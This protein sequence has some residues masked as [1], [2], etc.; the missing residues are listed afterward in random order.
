M[1]V[2]TDGVLLGAWVDVEN[3]RSILDVGTG[4]G[5]VA[6]MI[7]QRC[8]DACIDAID[9]DQA[10]CKQAGENFMSS[11]WHSRLRSIH[12][13]F[14]IFAKSS[15]KYELI[16]SN[17]PYFSNSLQPFKNT[18]KIARHTI[19]LTLSQFFEACLPLMDYN[20]EVCLIIPFSSATE[21][22][23]LAA[24]H[25][26]FPARSCEVSS[27]QGHPPVRSMITFSKKPIKE[28][29]EKLHLQNPDGSFTDAYKLLTKEFYVN[30]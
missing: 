11:L 30:F 19:E 3:K 13:D 28:T 16:V 14:R 8:G 15:K 17:P 21:C 5:L 9:I 20:G 4:C 22:R 1:K 24:I 29:T 7:A 27:K 26:L 12:A 23:R 10:S 6:L 2:G 25:H 18:R